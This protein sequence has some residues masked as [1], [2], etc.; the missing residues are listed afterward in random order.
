VPSGA[1]ARWHE[2]ASPISPMTEKHKSG[3]DIICFISDTQN[4][5]KFHKGCCESPTHVEMKPLY[6]DKFD[7]K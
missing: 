4:L 7:K 5:G 6:L 1:E 2:T 3:Q